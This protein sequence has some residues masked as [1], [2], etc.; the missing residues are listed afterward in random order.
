MLETTC[1]TRLRDKTL[2]L[3][4]NRP[5]HLTLKQISA[6]TTLPV[7]W[8]KMFAQG[9]IKEPSCNRIETLYEFLSGEQLKV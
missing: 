4:Q 5:V 9:Q 6:A 8:L 7:G 2:S 1:S 3:V